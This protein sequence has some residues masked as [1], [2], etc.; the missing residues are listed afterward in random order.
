MTEVMMQHGGSASEKVLVCIH[1]T[2]GT[3]PFNRPQKRCEESMYVV[4]AIEDSPKNTA[5]KVQ[6]EGGLQDR[7]DSS[8]PIPFYRKRNDVIQGRKKVRWVT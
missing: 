4:R 1:F 8:V 5:A 3:G 6:V 2:L 7:Y